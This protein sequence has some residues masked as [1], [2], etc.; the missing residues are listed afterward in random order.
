[1]KLKIDFAMVLLALFF[2]GVWVGMFFVVK[3]LW[4]KKE[5]K[6][7][8]KHWNTVVAFVALLVTILLF[9]IGGSLIFR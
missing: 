1:M 7:L 3:V 5:G 4:G 6:K 2:L 9:I 8:P